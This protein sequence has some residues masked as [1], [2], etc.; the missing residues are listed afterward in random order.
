ML[1]VR[2]LAAIAFY[3]KSGWIRTGTAPADWVLPDGRRAVEHRY[4]PGR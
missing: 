3:E 1:E 4:V 2:E